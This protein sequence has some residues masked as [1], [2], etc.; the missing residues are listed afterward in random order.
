[1]V[2]I[3][4]ST[5]IVSGQ[6]QWTRTAPALDTGEALTVSSR[7]ARGPDG[8]VWGFWGDTL[9]RLSG[10]NGTMEKIVNTGAGAFAFH[11]GDIYIANGANIY[12]VK[13]L[14]QSDA[15]VIAVP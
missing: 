8:W 4:G 5:L 6:M 11:N 1:L 13:G 2:L 15:T 9:Y 10:L 14:F 3:L 12:Q 7:L